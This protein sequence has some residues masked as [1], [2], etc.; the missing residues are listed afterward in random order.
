MPLK[1]TR[2]SSVQFI[3]DDRMTQILQVHSNLVGSTGQQTTEN[4]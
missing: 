3:P 4:E 2:L 1:F